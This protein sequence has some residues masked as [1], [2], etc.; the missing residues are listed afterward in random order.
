MAE[1]VKN[2]KETIPVS[3]TQP[4]QDID[5]ID[6]G[7]VEKTKQKTLYFID[8]ETGMRRSKPSKVLGGIQIDSLGFCGQ[9]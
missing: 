3:A 2:L 8:K 4:A 1:S 6:L 9:K 7:T 5:L